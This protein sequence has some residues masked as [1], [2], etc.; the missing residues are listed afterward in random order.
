MFPYIS[1]ERTGAFGYT[2]KRVFWQTVVN[3]QRPKLVVQMNGVDI[4]G[5]IQELML[6]YFPKSL[7][8]QIDHFRR[9]TH[10]L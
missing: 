3:D 5:W 7:R 1:K 10:N 8:I 9:F 6:A 2:G 4:E